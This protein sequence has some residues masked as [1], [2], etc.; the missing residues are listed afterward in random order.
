MAQKAATWA[1][2]RALELDEQHMV[3]H[4][5]RLAIV[6]TVHSIREMDDD[7]LAGALKY[8]RDEVARFLDID[9]SDPRVKWVNKWEP[10]RTRRRIGVTIEFVDLAVHLATLRAEIDAQLAALGIKEAS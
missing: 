5:D 6:L 8:Y 9:D 4:A 7:N 10:Y 2:L 3:R 1:A